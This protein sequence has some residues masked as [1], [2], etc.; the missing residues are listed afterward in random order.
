MQDSPA[1][2]FLDERR[3][4]SA[5]DT[6]QFECG[7]SL[8]K[9]RQAFNW[10]QE[11]LAELVGVRPNAISRFEMGVNTPRDRTR[12]AIACALNCEVSDI[13]PPLERRY[14]MALARVVAA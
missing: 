4:R 5:M 11:Q 8:R 13:W 9:R 3:L 14:V 10:S 7:D 2:P 12:V 1:E 6:W